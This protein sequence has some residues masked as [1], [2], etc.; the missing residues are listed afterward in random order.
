[1]FFRNGTQLLNSKPRLLLLLLLALNFVVLSRSIPILRNR[2][3]SHGRRFSIGWLLDN[4]NS[5]ALVM[6]ICT[7]LSIVHKHIRNGHI[8]IEI[9][10]FM[11]I[12]EEFFDLKRS[13]TKRESAHAQFP[14][15]R[16]SRRR[17]SLYTRPQLPPFFPYNSGQPTQCDIFRVL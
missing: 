1:V 16:K 4:T 7:R 5:P 12:I 11:V 15:S 2:R 6:A 8:S 13:K 10:G 14:R 3:E 17:H 9:I